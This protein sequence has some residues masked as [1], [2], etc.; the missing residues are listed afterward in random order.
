MVIGIGLGRTFQ[1]TLVVEAAAGVPADSLA[2]AAMTIKGDA[3]SALPVVPGSA[4]AVST[5]TTLY[6]PQVVFGGGY[7]TS[8]V[9]MAGTP[10]SSQPKVPMPPGTVASALIE[11]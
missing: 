3:L 9:L 2:V 8:F 7:S 5:G 11:T 10:S 1:G 6:F 4:S